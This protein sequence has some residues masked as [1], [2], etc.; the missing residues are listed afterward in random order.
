[1]GRLLIELFFVSLSVGLGEGADVANCKPSYVVAPRYPI[2][3]FQ[4]R[5]SGE[6]TIEVQVSEAGRVEAVSRFDG[7]KIFR[8]ASEEAARSW[9]TRRLLVRAED[10]R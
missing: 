4:A 6:V 3:A 10:A 9:N 1:M 8:A 2:L 7:D 5:V